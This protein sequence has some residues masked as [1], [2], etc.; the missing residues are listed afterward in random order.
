[1]EVVHLAGRKEKT[2][3]EAYASEYA[4]SAGDNALPRSAADESIVAEWAANEMT[5]RKAADCG[6]C[7]KG[8]K[9]SKSG[10]R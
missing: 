9:K 1:M 2:R 3:S 5:F 6:V 8:R 7:R 4:M 10:A